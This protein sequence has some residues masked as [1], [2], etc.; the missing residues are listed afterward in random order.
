M[1]MYSQLI[2]RDLGFLSLKPHTW[3][4]LYA[5]LVEDVQM[6]GTNGSKYTSPAGMTV[7]I[8]FASEHSEDVGITDAL[9]EPLDNQGLQH[10]RAFI[11]FNELWK[12]RREP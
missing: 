7:K 11:P 12:I 8:T 10:T 3:T 2:P 4:H 5:T 6:V 9:D 1:Q